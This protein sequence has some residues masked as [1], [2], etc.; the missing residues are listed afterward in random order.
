MSAKFR[1]PLRR[2]STV[3]FLLVAGA[4]SAGAQPE[5]PGAASARVVAVGDV[6]GAFP[7]FVTILQRAGLIDQKLVWTGGSAVLVQTGDIPD[8]GPGT[9]AALDL[10]M[11][12][13]A[14]AQKQ[15]GKVLALLG[16]HEVMTMT[17]DL[18]YVSIEDYRSFLTEQS[19]KLRQLTKVV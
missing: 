10:L 12:L 5:S 14:Q 3:C 19:V 15:N 6:H 4:G 2:A 8:R 13:E 11:R 18:R 1:S 9:R 17:G 7:E 16:N